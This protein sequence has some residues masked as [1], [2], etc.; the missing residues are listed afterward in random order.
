[1]SDFSSRYSSFSYTTRY[2][3]GK[4]IKDISPSKEWTSFYTDITKLPANV[5]LVPAGM[6]GR[7]DLLSYRLYG[8]V[9]YWWVLLVA[10]NIVD[11]FEQLV[12]GKQI[13]VPIID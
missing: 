9:D 4:P 1:M 6:E 3:R 8:T 12:A 5:T 2:H 10:N 7:P 11:P 13:R